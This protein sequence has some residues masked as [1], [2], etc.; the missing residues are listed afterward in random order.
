[1]EWFKDQQ[2]LHKRY[3]AQILTKFQE[4][5][6]SLPTLLYIQLPSRVDDND[7]APSS[8]SL[9]NDTRRHITVCGDTHGQF[10]DL[11]NI[12]EQG[13]YPSVQNPYLFNGD[14]VDRGSFSFENIFT[15]ICWRM[16]HP[17]CMYLLRGN[18]E[19]KNMNK[20]YGFEGEILHKYDKT[21]M[22]IFTHIFNNIPLSAVIQNTVFVA[23]G[24]LSTINDG[25]VTLADISKISRNRE[26]ND[27]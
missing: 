22:N 24:G 13:G 4:E 10:Y 3:V 6:L 11:C 25:A 23:H 7:S 19:T 15:L 1:M 26:P 2:T 8:S 5:V 9:Q 18:H 21:V 27:T 16:V 12:F 20:I 14:Y 17:N